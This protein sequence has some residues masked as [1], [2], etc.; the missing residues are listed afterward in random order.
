MDASL[1]SGF[2]VRDSRTEV[3]K[4]HASFANVGSDIVTASTYQMTYPGFAKGG[5]ERSEA[6]TLFNDAMLCAREGGSALTAASI[7]PY[8]AYLADGSEYTGMYGVAG[9][10]SRLTE[11][12]RD[13]M[14]TLVKTD[15]DI[16][17]CETVPCAT[18]VRALRTLLTCEA[19]AAYAKPS[20]ISMSVR[21]DE[22]GRSVCL[23]SGESIEDVC[24]LMEDPRG[25][26]DL[27]TNPGAIGL[28]VNCCA[29]EHVTPALTIM[30]D[31]VHKSRALVAYPN[32]GEIWDA[33]HKVW[34]SGTRLHE[35]DGGDDDGDDENGDE[36]GAVA[37]AR[38]WVGL[39]SRVVGG[40]CR[41][42]PKDIRKLQSLKDY[43]PNNRARTGT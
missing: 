12:H 17:A 36:S 37:L 35:Q 4:A 30:R 2:A 5:V 21:S 43:I 41:T 39:G 23:S 38:T 40:C 42:T 16:I 24:R 19:I 3:V 22:S 9:E 11:W 7:G 31:F 26:A 18:E 32:S 27:E 25:D 1:W 15:A 6:Q 34:H 20:W 28:G 14:E 33:E 10:Q 8:G 13:K 29:P